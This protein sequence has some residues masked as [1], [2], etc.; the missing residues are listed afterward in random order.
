MAHAKEEE[1][2]CQHGV[3][4]DTADVVGKPD[5]YSVGI[6]NVASVCGLVER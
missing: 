4:V 2:W 5:E 6:V 1:P 3:S